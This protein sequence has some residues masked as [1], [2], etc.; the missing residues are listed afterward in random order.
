MTNLARNAR[1]ARLN[2]LT[3]KGYEAGLSGQPID[4]DYTHTE[5]DRAAWENG[6]RDGHKAR[7][8]AAAMAR[9]EGEQR[10]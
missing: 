10:Q 6:W 5:L 7:E 9:E 1:K 8:H 2:A 3:A 4:S